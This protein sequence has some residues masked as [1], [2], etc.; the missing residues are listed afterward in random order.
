MP[1]YYKLGIIEAIIAS[2]IALLSKLSPYDFKWTILVAGSL[3][4]NG[5]V[6]YY[7]GKFYY[8]FVKKLRKDLGDNISKNMVFYACFFFISIIVVFA[9]ANYPL[10]Y[11]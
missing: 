8:I 9:I 4:L 5:I 7:M 2:I 1:R 3:V 11:R 10:V 6:V